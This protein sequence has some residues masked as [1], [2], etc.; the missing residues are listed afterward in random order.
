[1][2]FFASC[3]TISLSY[4]FVKYLFLGFELNYP[5]YIISPLFCV[6]SLDIMD[7][8]GGEEDGCKN[9]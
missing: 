8:G 5:S 2:I 4:S 1:M 7:F 3:Q 6:E 9:R